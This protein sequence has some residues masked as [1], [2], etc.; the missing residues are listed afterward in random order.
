MKDDVSLL[1]VYGSLRTGDNARARLHGFSRREDGAFPTIEPDPDGAVD[2]EL[3]IVDD[4][5][6]MDTYEGRDPM[7]AETSYYWLLETPEGPRVYV[8]NPSVGRWGAEYTRK[9]A[10][11]A[12]RDAELEVL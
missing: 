9:S 4:W 2:G 6:E 3:F 7:D 8:G 11:E 1:F 10:A 5:R 12:M